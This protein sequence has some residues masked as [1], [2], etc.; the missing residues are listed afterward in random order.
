LIFATT[1]AS[2][3]GCR[4]AFSPPAMFFTTAR[5]RLAQQLR[6]AHYA[7]RFSFHH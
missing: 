3:F 6:R 2:H 1:A 4:R 7:A 5:R